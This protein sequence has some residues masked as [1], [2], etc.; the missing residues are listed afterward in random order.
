MTRS[1]ITFF[2][3][4]FATVVAA[5]EF[6]ASEKEQIGK[7]A[8]DYLVENPNFLI[9]ASKKL[10]QQQMEEQ[11]SN[12]AKSALEKDNLKRLI[13]NTSTPYIGPKNAKVVVIEFFDYQCLF[14]S[15]IA[16]SLLTAVKDNP[17][18]KFI[19]K[20]Y[21]IFGEQWKASNYAAN[22]GIH[23]FKQGG[24]K[25]YHKYHD[26]IFATGKDE[27]KLQVAD[28][29]KI[30][31]KFKVAIA[32]AAEDKAKSR[33][34]KAENA[35]D[36]AAGSDKIALLATVE[37]NMELG[38]DM[39]IQGTPFIIVMP[40]EGATKENTTVFAGYPVPPS[41]GE[42]AATQAIQDAIDKAVEASEK[43]GDDSE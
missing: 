25:L 36:S 43:I 21:P 22:V 6:T 1:L 30:A 19:F 11:Q 24:S 2:I 5:K 10:Q 15:K 17:D 4:L 31:K 37:D 42:A 39:H 13:Q 33:K 38:K 27:G 9:E 18:V 20:D 34:S 23:A 32:N 41:K 8:S 26:A 40:T 35:S 3:A 12:Y 16:P 29:N 28:I 7:I 14:C